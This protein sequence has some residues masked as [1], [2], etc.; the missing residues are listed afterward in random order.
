MQWEEYREAGV[1]AEDSDE[2]W[3]AVN[4]NHKR[5]NAADQLKD[6]DS[7]FHYYQKL[8]ALRK[9]L[10]VIAYGDIE[11]LAEHDPSVFAYRRTYE[12]HERGMIANYYGKEYTWKSA[13]EGEGCRKV[14]GNYQGGEMP[15]GGARALKPYE[16]AV[17]YK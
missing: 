16:A 4:G 11:P 7:I 8:I 3:I 5:V 13:P 10:D 9:E 1:A 14:L 12:G 17:W 6:E 15:E 2:P